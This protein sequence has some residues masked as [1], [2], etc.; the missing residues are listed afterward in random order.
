VDFSKVLLKGL[1]SMK[2]F[3]RASIAALVLAG[4]VAS[5]YSQ[6]K[7]VAAPI[8][9]Q[10]VSATMP[11]PNCPPNDPNACGIGRF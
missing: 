11:A 1:L 7:Q 8:S 4:F 3:V 10:A 5:S 6:Q 2:L 9:R